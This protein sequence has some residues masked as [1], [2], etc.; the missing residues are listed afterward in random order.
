MRLL[1]ARRERPGAVRRPGVR[2]RHRRPG[3]RTPVEPLSVVRPGGHPHPDGGHRRAHHRGPRLA[4]VHL[5]PGLS[6]RPGPSGTRV[7][8]C[9]LPDGGTGHAGAAFCWRSSWRCRSRCPGRPRNTRR[10]RERHLG[11]PA[12]GSPQRQSMQA[13]RILLGQ[14]NPR[15]GPR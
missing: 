7:H 1:A 15:S 13:R 11:G 14:Q 2:S 8:R 4:A 12:A 3:G 5:T 6:R 9:R 10:R